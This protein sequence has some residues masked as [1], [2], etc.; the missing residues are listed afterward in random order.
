[1]VCEDWSDEAGQDFAAER[2]ARFSMYQAGQSCIA[3]QRVFCT[4]STTRACGNGY[5]PGSACCPPVHPT[6]T[7]PMSVH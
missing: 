1:M 7:L 6:T 3:V 5:C 4:T 2:I